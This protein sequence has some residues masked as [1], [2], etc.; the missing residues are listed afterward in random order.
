MRIRQTRILPSITSGS[1]R[2]GYSLIELVVVLATI[3]L[4]TIIAGVGAYTVLEDTQQNTARAAIHEVLL[5]EK[6]FSESWGGYT[7]Y[8]DELSGPADL[9]LV[10]G[11]SNDSSE[12]SIAVGTD[13]IL[14]LAVR[15]STQECLFIRASSLASGGEVTALDSAIQKGIVCEGAGALSAKEGENLEARDTPRA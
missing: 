10:N 15:R 12:I 9:T 2:L 3:S 8:T 7:S 14:G 1:H 11:V 5:T 4:L 6:V 13:G